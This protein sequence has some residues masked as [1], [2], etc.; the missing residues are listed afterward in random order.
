MWLVKHGFYRKALQD[1]INLV[2]ENYD[3]CKQTVLFQHCTLY[4]SILWH[5]SSMPFPI[6][7]SLSHAVDLCKEGRLKSLS[8]PLS[9]PPPCA[10]TPALVQFSYRWQISFHYRSVG[11]LSYSYNSL[12]PFE[13]MCSVAD[14]NCNIPRI[15][16]VPHVSYYNGAR[17]NFCSH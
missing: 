4:N 2:S 1:K 9:P 10:S 12:F 7:I 11:S 17:P 13:V 5:L 3:V 14:Y 8:H 15:Y 16:I 6:L